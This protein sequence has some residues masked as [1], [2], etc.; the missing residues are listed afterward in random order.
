MVCQRQ[1]P[2]AKGAESAGGD[3][4][5]NWRAVLRVAAIA[6]NA[7]LAVWLFGAAAAWNRDPVGGA[8]IAI[9]PI[10]AIVALV[11]CRHET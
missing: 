1:L 8:I 10:L 5:M 3:E 9:P 2:V 6:L 7:V 11:T 4:A